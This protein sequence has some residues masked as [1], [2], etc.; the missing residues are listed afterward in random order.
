MEKDTKSD[1]NAVMK[2]PDGLIVADATNQ[3]AGR[4]ASRTAKKLLKGSRV[5]IV[6]AENAVVSGNPVST[7]KLYDERIKR[8]DPY[9]GPFHSRMPDR[10]LKRMIRGMLPYKKATG[11]NAFK[12]LSVYISVP[13]E[14][15][16]RETKL[17][18]E[19]ALENKFTTL[20]EL[21]LK[22]GAKKTW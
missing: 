19:Q 9:H 5:L 12:R 14:L 10:M 20:G 1:T 3:I 18:D 8:G 4:L 6:N 17:T 21:A 11:K 13:E 22:L 2:N 15:K 7:A 16:G